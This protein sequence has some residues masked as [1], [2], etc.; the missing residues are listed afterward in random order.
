VLILV[1]C[2]PGALGG[3]PYGRK[4]VRLATKWDTSAGP[5]SN[6]HFRDGGLSGLDVEA[7]VAG[8]RS[9]GPFCMAD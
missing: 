1:G 4:N 9:F 5:I 7:A 6:L 3:E 8:S 2:P